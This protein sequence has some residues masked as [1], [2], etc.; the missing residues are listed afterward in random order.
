LPRLLL[1]LALAAGALPA[2][3][4]EM[5][6]R[7]AAARQAAASTPCAELAPFYWEI[8]DQHQV[9]VSQSVG[10]INADTSMPIASASKW[11]FAAYVV[12]LRLGRLSEGE[13]EALTMRSGYTSMQ[14]ASCLKLRASRRRVQ[15]VG[16]CFS[17]GQNSHYTPAHR[18]KF[19]YNGGHFQKLAS[20]DLKLA[21]KN[22]AELAAVMQQALGITF[23]FEFTTPQP[24]GGITTTAAHY[25]LFLQ[26]LLNG[27]LQLGSRL[28][29]HAACTQP[30]SC[31]AALSTP[32]PTQLA[33]GYSLGHWVEADA[34]QRQAAFSSAGAF[35]FYP[36]IESGR[37]YYGILARDDR[38]RRA[39]ADSAECGARIRT[40]FLQPARRAALP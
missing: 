26:A 25:R 23:P 20:V 2:A 37:R 15:T 10:K 3:A 40:A 16:D 17:T 31:R 7:V 29:E 9:W 32:A 11:V 38:S 21:D 12:E 39:G 35:G 30:D 24:A 19:Y 34:T 27:Q 33:W 5:D 18:G 36:W 14:H 13:I 8:G 6:A 4:A 28:G 1:A 22:S